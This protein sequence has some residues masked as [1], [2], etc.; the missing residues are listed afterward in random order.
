[1]Q[2]NINAITIGSLSKPLEIYAIKLKGN[3]SKSLSETTIVAEKADHTL[4][5]ETKKE[6]KYEIENFKDANEYDNFQ[7]QS[8]G[9]DGTMKREMYSG[10]KGL[11]LISKDASSYWYTIMPKCTPLSQYDFLSFVATGPAGGDFTIRL[12]TKVDCNSEETVN[13]VVKASDFGGKLSGSQQQISIPLKDL[14]GFNKKVH[15]ISAIVLGHLV[16]KG[17]THENSTPA[18]LNIKSIS[19]RG[20]DCEKEKEVVKPQPESG[21]DSHGGSNHDGTIGDN[22]PV[23]SSLTVSV[24]LA[25]IAFI[26]LVFNL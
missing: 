4:P 21:K 20:V 26:A 10:E 19:L 15:T 24:S 8:H 25:T 23:S 7:K 17:E 3:C 1:L 16:N 9:T 22:D 6:C 5:E 11:S 18:A 13:F 2:K 12:K 14:P